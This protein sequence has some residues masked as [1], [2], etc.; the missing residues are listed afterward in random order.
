MPYLSVCS[1]GTLHRQH[2]G[3]LACGHRRHLA[4]RTG[5]SGAG[6]P[7]PDQVVGKDHAER[8][9]AT[10]AHKHGMAEAERF[11]LGLNTRVCFG[12]VPSTRA[13]RSLC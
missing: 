4:Q 2:T 3:L 5:T 6:A 10:A 8:L 1:R 9:V 12:N 7:V 11:G 13:S